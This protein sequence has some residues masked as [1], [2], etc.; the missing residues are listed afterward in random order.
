[1]NS[2]IKP[3][4][5]RWRRMVAAVTLDH[6]QGRLEQQD[7]P[8]LAGRAVGIVGSAKGTLLHAVSPEAAAAGVGPGMRWGE[9][10]SRCPG[11]ARVVASP[12][13][14]DEAS[15]RLMAALA[16]VAPAIEVFGRDQAFLDLTDCQAYYRH[17]P[18]RIAAM[19][20]TAVGEAVGLPCRVGISGDKTTARQAARLADSDQVGVVP[21]AAAASFLAPLSIEE[22]LGG[23]SG[24]AEFLARHDIHRC[25]DMKKIPIHLPA[26]RFGNLG[27]RLWLMAQGQD[28][29]P[30]LSAPPAGCSH[31]QQRRLPATTRDLVLLQ[32]VLVDLAG[33][34]TGQLRREKVL[35]RQFR[36]ALCAPEG[37][38]EE[39]VQ[40]ER[41]T[42]DLRAIA[43]LCMRFLRQHWYGEPVSELR[44]QA[45]PWQE[46]IVQT[47]IFLTPRPARRGG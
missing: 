26:R 46:P 17:D 15:A 6:F 24:I 9:A 20:R 30:V 25:G 33:K 2:I 19:I 7:N 45:W 18:A 47:D 1:M 42:D 44:L 10:E 14:Y 32:T 41:A 27:R 31:S 34:L 39:D 21:P 8:L 22:V 12:G 35:A 5:Q 3:P 29:A 43:P 38:R 40:S 13:R 28:P 37:W 36:V 4:L 16:D 11:L 23:G